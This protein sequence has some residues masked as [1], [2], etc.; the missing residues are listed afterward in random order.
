MPATLLLASAITKR[1]GARTLLDAV[2]LR[3]DAGT[4]LAI[5]GPNGSGKSTLMQIVAGR[6]PADG[7]S[8]NIVI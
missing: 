8:V 3:V 1:Y 7:G 4:R 2:D 6:E 5:T